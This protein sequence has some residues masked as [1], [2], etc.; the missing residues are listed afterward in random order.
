MDD[1]HGTLM[2]AHQWTLMALMDIVLRYLK[3]TGSKFFYCFM[4]KSMKK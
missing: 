4:W 1:D 3:G 2:G